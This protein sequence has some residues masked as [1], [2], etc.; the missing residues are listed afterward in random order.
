MG[1]EVVSRDD[2]LGDRPPKDA[3]GNDRSGFHGTLLGEGV[4]DSISAVRSDTSC[5]ERRPRRPATL[6]NDLLL[7]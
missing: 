6:K 3:R 7:P 2:A 4:P 1:R 5:K